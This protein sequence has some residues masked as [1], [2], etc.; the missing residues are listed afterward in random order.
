MIYL[1]N[2]DVDTVVASTL[3]VLD[4][5]GARL[6]LPVYRGC[7]HPLVEPPHFCPEIHGKDS[8]GDLDP[9]L[10]PLSAHRN[11]AP[12]HAVTALLAALHASADASVTL[13]C[14]APLTNLACALRTDAKVMAAKVGPQP[15][16]LKSANT[17]T[18]RRSRKC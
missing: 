13:V 18:P 16:I 7:A 3:K 6:D 10:P 12:G 9:P 1:G 4:A 11:A 5:A 17:N 14:L 2:A 15:Y 8:L